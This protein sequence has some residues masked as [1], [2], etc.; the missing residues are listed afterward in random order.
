MLQQQKLGMLKLE[1]NIDSLIITI[2]ITKMLKLI[3]T[4]MHAFQ[5]R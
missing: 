3:A 5:E 4:K 1:A 2:I